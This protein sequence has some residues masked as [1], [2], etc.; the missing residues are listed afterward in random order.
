MT[1]YSVFFF[2][3]LGGGSTLLPPTEKKSKFCL[4]RIRSFTVSGFGEN[5]VEI[6]LVD[7]EKLG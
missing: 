4:D 7:S 6:G 5:L 1:E 3:F 2:F